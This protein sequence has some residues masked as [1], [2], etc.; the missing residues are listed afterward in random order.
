MFYIYRQ[1]IYLV[2]TLPLNEFIRCH[3]KHLFHQLVDDNEKTN[4]GV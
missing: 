4:V 2:D 1:F 3:K